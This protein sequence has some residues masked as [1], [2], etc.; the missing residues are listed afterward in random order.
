[1]KKGIVLMGCLM[2]L[3]IGTIGCGQ[4]SAGNKALK[5]IVEN[6]DEKEESEKTVLHTADGKVIMETTDDGMTMTD[7]KGEGSIKTGDAAA[8][9][10]LPKEIYSYPN[11]E[12]GAVVESPQEKM[13]D[14]KT[15]DGLKIV[16]AAM[17]ENMLKMGWKTMTSEQMDQ[18]GFL[19]MENEKQLVRIVVSV[20][21]GM[22]GLN[23]TLKSKIKE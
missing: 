8:T 19:T 3:V 14:L 13:Y 17:K 23:I 10:A 22:T 9:T 7:E 6:A 1:M 16:F 21:E 15:K 11:A 2:L 5:D 4:K 18:A 20:N 12:V